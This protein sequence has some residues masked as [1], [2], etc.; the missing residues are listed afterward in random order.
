VIIYPG[1][2]I[3]GK[4]HIGNNCEIGANIVVTHDI[5]DNAIV[6]CGEVRTIKIKENV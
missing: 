6:V 1:A 4:V 3:V 5:P 2:K